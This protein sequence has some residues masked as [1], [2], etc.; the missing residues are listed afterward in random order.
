[1][2]LR[3][4]M[5]EKERESYLAKK[6][7]IITCFRALSCRFSKFESVFRNV[8]EPNSTKVG[9]HKAGNFPDCRAYISYPPGFHVF[10]SIFP[11]K[12][13]CSK[14]LTTKV[15]KVKVKKEN[16][17]QVGYAQSPH[18]GI[19]GKI[20]AKYLCIVASEITVPS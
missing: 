7:N 2:C 11:A 5:T 3:T 12:N 18:E 16:I 13:F 19:L 1:M 8:S 15:Q 9:T 10:L 6:P 14:C 20:A 4:I 17:T